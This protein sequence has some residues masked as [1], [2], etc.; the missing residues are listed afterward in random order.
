MNTNPRAECLEKNPLPALPPRAAPL[1][2]VQP[3][4]PTQRARLGCNL[5]G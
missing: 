2:T 3:L 4:C 1:T 5:D